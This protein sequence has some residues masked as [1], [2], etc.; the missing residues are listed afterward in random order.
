MPENLNLRSTIS[1]RE[2]FKFWLKLGFISFGG[3][4]GQI[5][6]VHQELVEKKRWI[7]E[8]RFLH[9]LNYCMVLPGPEALQLVIY[10][11]WLMHRTIG[12]LVAGLLFILPSLILLIGLSAI[13]VTYGN[14]VLITG[15][16]LGIKPAVTAIV[17]YAGYRIGKRIL[18]G[19]LHWGIAILSFIAIAFIHLPYPAIIVGAGLLGYLCS[20]YSNNFSNTSSGHS[21]TVDKSGTQ[22]IIGDDTPTPPHAIFAKKQLVMSIVG[23]IIAWGVPFMMIV[24]LWG[25][26][27]I[28]ASLS[29]FFTKAALLTFGGAYAVLPYVFQA[30]VENFHWLSASQMIDGLAL[31]ETTP[32]PLIIVVAFVGYLAAHAEALISTMNVSPFLAGALGAIIVSWFIFLPSFCF[33]FIGGP[34]IEST[35]KELR[36]APAMTAISCAV[37]GVIASLSLFFAIHTI[38]PK[39]LNQTLTNP[40]WVSIVLLALATVSL[41]KFEQSVIRVLLGCASIGLLWH[42]MTI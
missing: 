36:F 11:G 39:G 1:L 29:L 14:T 19:P 2:A 23:S 35:H 16:F 40:S 5:A 18:K 4:A 28:F 37:V 27:S 22:A 30:A 17:L 42:W 38:W 24:M 32:G 12:G 15:I 10:I 13:Y 6:T 9:A 3:P 7:S 8:S 33:I 25:Q 20:R 41:I 31:G 34:L 21:K 26:E